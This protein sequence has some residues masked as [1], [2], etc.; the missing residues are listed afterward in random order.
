MNSTCLFGL[1]QCFLQGALNLL[2]A[3]RGAGLAD[4]TRIYQAS[5]S[6]MFG[7]VHEVPQSE[8]TPFHPRSPYGVAKVYA[9][10]IFVNYRCAWGLAGSTLVSVADP[11]QQVS[12]CSRHCRA[13]CRSV[14]CCSTEL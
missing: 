2:E 13:H 14:S 7:K 11:Q 8:T 9:Y 1:W 10:W 5:T 4:K 12:G 6:E 3:V